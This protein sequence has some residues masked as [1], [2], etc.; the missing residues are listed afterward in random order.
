[1]EIGDFA[2]VRRVLLLESS[3]EIVSTGYGTLRVLGIRIAVVSIGVHLDFP[4]RFS[5]MPSHPFLNGW[6]GCSSR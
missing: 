1:M 3:K 6:Q 4:A 5:G 2:T